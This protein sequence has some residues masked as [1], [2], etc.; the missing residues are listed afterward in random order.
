MGLS[1]V[2]GASSIIQPGVCT[3]TTRPAAPYHGQAIF[4]TDTNTVRIWLGTE[5]SLGT[6]HAATISVDYLVVAGGGASGG[7]TGG[8][9]GAGGMRCTVTATGGSGS[10]ESALGATA[11]TTYTVTVG[12]GAAGGNSGVGSTGA[13]GS[14]SVFSTI[15][16]SYTHLTLPTNRE[17]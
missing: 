3:S 11:G 10:L 2:S 5:W 12:A 15:T 7:N 13:S 16:V 1:S 8:G 6:V 9:G 14:N 17:V 4:E